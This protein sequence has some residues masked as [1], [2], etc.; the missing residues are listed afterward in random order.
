MESDTRRNRSM[1][2]VGRAK[3]R[4]DLCIAG[5][6]VVTFGPIARSGPA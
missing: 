5:P 2:G 1:G 6:E 4:G 3:G